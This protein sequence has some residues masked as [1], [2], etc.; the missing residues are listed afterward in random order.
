MI[1]VEKAK[2]TQLIEYIKSKLT[3][4][5][6]YIYIYILCVYIVSNYIRNSYQSELQKGNKIKLESHIESEYI[7]K[8][9]TGE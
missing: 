3:T 2:Q 6:Q 4:K 1:V 7:L 9:S 8:R 5:I